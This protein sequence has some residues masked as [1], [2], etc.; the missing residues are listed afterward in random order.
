MCEIGKKC[1]FHQKCLLMICIMLEFIHSCLFIR[2]SDVPNI[3]I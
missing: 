3:M 1:V 2:A